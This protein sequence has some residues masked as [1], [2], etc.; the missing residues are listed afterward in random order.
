MAARAIRL[1]KAPHQLL[2]FFFS[3]IIKEGLMEYMS[4]FLNI[5]QGWSFL[6][7]LGILVSLPPTAASAASSESMIS[8]SSVSSL[9]VSG[10]T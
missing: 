2:N 5:S 7:S 9:P 6:L 4:I 1:K 8:I 10:S 3:S